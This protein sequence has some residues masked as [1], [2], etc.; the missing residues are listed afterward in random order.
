MT[1]DEVVKE[2]DD[3]WDL[4]HEQ[5]E[6]LR[7]LLDCIPKA[8][9]RDEQADGTTLVACPSCGRGVRP[10]WVCCPECGARLAEEE[11]AADEQAW[12]SGW[13]CGW[14]AANGG[15]GRDLIDSDWQ[16]YRRIVRPATPKPDRPGIFAVRCGRCGASGSTRDVG[17]EHDCAATKDQPR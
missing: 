17:A 8:P 4:T 1:R 13:S 5:K 12:R 10:R 15:C 14:S 2:F 3:T 16:E 6:H 9:P 7:T 11:R